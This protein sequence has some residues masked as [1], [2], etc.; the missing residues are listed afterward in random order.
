M[1]FVEVT[2][3]PE[4]EKSNSE[5]EEPSSPS[6]VL[7]SD[8][9]NDNVADQDSDKMFSALK[10]VN[11]QLVEELNSLSNMIEVAVTSLKKIHH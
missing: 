6:S 9:N 11:N 3:T 1:S 4:T 5:S 8:S 10:D 7:S 2:A